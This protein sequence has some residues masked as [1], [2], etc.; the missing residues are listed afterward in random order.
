M[1]HIVVANLKKFLLGTFHG[2]TGHY[3]HEYIFDVRLSFQSS[4]IARSAAATVA[5]CSR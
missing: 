1:V 2:V 4:L 5:E 3:L